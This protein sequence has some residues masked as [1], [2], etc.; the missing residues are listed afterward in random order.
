MAE[1]GGCC[2]PQAPFE[3]W[4]WQAVLIADVDLLVGAAEE[5][6]TPKGW[7]AMRPWLEAGAA[8]VLPAFETPFDVTGHVKLPHPE[9]VGRAA[10]FR[11]VSGEGTGGHTGEALRQVPPALLWTAHSPTLWA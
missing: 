4:P 2:I 10:A 1:P 5:L 3:S 7:A 11:A 9:A 6:G 8:V